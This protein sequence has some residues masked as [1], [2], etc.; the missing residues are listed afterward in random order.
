M[1]FSRFA[2]MLQRRRI[3]MARVDKLDDEW[4][5]ALAGDQL[6][7]VY[8]TAP[9]RQ[10]SNAKPDETDEERT[11]RIIDLWRRET[12]VSCWCASDH[13]SH[14]LWR[15]YCGPDE[16][17]SVQTTLAKLQQQFQNISLYG[18]RYEH[19]GKTKSTPVKL[20]LATIK[21]P[22]FS[23][24]HEVRFIA[25]PDYNNPKLNKG[26]FGFEYDIEPEQFI[27]RIV[28]HP[29]ADLS[30]KETVMLLVNG[31]S[32]SLREKVVW[33]EMRG[34]PPLAEKF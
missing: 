14:A 2:W 8:A 13:E 9:I 19:P 23:Y 26:E 24:E 18:I 32:P 31:L 5:M 16:G 28:I 6:K 30:F 33:S 17:I 25:E 3:W 12:F 10:L 4:E 22:M 15:I 7:H 11:K 34:G 21:R 27:E 29:L 1:T 20:D